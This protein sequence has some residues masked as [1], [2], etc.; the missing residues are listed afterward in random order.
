M[1]S[2]ALVPVLPP[3]DTRTRFLGQ[4]VD[5]VFVRGLDVVDA[6]APAVESSDHNPVIATLRLQER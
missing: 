2:I 1:A 4:Q 5:Y 3:A 6:E